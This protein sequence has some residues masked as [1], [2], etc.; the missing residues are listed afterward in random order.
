MSDQFNYF[1]DTGRVEFVILNKEENSVKIQFFSGQFQVFNF[2]K[3]SIEAEKLYN[4]IL[5]AIANENLN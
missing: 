1:I 4:A 2:S 5:T 3:N